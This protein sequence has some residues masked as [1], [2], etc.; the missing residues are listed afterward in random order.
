VTD[1]GPADPGGGA[2]SRVADG[3]NR[4]RAS[5]ATRSGLLC[6]ICDRARPDTA[7]AKPDTE[8]AVCDRVTARME[9]DLA[10]RR[11][12]QTRDLLAQQW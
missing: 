7:A 3:A 4:V 11:S 1:A 9:A 5:S 2:R 8:H 10:A 6:A 12:G